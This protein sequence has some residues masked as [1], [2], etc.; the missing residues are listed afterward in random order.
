MTLKRASRLALLCP[1]PNPVLFQSFGT[2]DPGALGCSIDWWGAAPLAGWGRKRRLLPDSP[3]SAQT[4]AFRRDL[5]SGAAGP[6]DPRGTQL[7]DTGKRAPNPTDWSPPRPPRTMRA[8]PRAPRAPIGP[9]AAGRAARATPARVRGA[10]RGG[11]GALCAAVS[12]GLRGAGRGGRRHGGAEQRGRAGLR[13]RV[14]PEQEAPQ[15]ACA[16]A[17][18]PR[19]PDVLRDSPPALISPQGKLE[20]LVKWR[21]WS[22]K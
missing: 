12:R 8:P 7:L 17:R 5:R 16:P 20:Y 14:H 4:M 3:P 6:Q 19:A 11:G 2:P 9:A 21:G 1:S 18:P 15:G 10:G 13:R 22:S